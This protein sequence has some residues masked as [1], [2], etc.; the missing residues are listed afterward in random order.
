MTTGTDASI[1]SWSSEGQGP[2]LPCLS[3]LPAGSQSHPSIWVRAVGD[4][5]PVC[6]LVTC[7]ILK[8]V[9]LL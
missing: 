5:P 4:Y 7:V 6:P 9:L 2:S 1:P 3:W 8:D